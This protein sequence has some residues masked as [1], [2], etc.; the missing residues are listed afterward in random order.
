MTTAPSAKVQTWKQ[1]LDY[2]WRV[3]WKR[4]TSAK[5]SACNANHITTY[6]GASLP[7]KRMTSPAWWLEFK[8]DME[9]NGRS[10]STINRIISA[11]STVMNFTK[12]AEL[13]NYSMPKF[14]RA[15]EGATRIEWFTK[16][17]V[18][19]LAFLS[20]DLYG[21]RWG[22]N[23]A[24]A[25]LFSAYTGVRQGE[26][27]KLKSCD[28]DSAHD[29]IW[30]GGKPGRLTKYKKGIRNITLHPKVQ[31]IVYDRLDQDFLFKENWNNKDQLYAAFVKVRNVA[32]FS[33][34]YVW[35]CL[36]H[37][38]GTWM[39][40][41]THPRTL[42]EALGHRTIEMSLKYCKA[43]DQAARSAVLAL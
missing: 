41:V 9:E 28:Y 15:E 32:G 2:T 34:D 36:R 6:A 19:R 12:L 35:H 29:Q 10:G 18:D 7:L 38:F 33:D 5:T 22:N 11:G 39:G 30:I 42:M 24:D 16:E 17:D 23:L 20:R 21:D 43:T 37:S 1:A 13:H 27:L 4:Q 25:I 26:L 31:Q 3:K 14:Q 8:A 40:A